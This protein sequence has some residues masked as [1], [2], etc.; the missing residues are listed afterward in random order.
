MLAG[1]GIYG[2]LSHLTEDR[3][4]E[5]ATRAAFGAAPSVVRD[6]VVREGSSLAAIGA[7]IG[8]AL[9]YMGGRIASSRL[10]EVPRFDLPMIGLAVTAV[11]AVTVIAFLVPALKAARLEP[12]EGLR[13]K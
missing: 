9:A 2:V 12:A 8:L 11:L 5:L 3:R 4:T 6:L 7:A 10:F 13:A 1:V